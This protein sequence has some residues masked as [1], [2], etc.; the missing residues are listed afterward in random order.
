MLFCLILE[1]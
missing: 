1:L